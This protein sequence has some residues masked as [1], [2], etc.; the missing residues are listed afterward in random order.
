MQCTL[1]GTHTNS[2]DQLASPPRAWEHLNQ[3]SQILAITPT[4]LPV[5]T[6]TGYQVFTFPPTLFKACDMNDLI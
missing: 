1:S 3:H 5:I 4:E 2:T 6:D